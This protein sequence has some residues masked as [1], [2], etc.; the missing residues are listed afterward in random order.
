MSESGSNRV[1]DVLVSF[2]VGLL[3]GAAGALLLAPSSGRDTRRRI[4]EL[5]EGLKERTEGVAHRATDLVRDQAHR[6][7]RAVNEGKQA[8]RDAPSTKSS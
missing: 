8:Y 4:G 7:E 1:A 3:V 5:A 2:S 6:L